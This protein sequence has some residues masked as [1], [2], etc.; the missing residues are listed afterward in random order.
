[1][2]GFHAWAA[3]EHTARERSAEEF[4]V[5]VEEAGLD[6]VEYRRTFGYFSGELATSLFNLPYDSTPLN[7]ALQ[8]LL[9]PACRLLARADT[10]SVQ[11]T[12]FAVAV[13]GRR[14]QGSE[15]RRRS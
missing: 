15:P 14:P 13:V 7:R 5:A 4:M 6:I 3:E 1:L 11:T 2:R 12:R 10:L 8:A 9:A